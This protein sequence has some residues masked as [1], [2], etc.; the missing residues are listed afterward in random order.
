MKKNVFIPV[1]ITGL[2]IA[3]SCGIVY[4][5]AKETQALTDTI[6][7]NL[8]QEGFEFII[9]FEKGEKHNHP[10]FVFW[11]EDMNENLLQTLFVTKSFATGI[12]GHAPVNDTL[13]GT[14][15]GQ[16]KRPAALPYWWHKCN[17]EAVEVAVPSPENPYVDAYTGETPE[18]SFALNIKTDKIPGEKFRVL[19]EINQTWDW[20][21]FWTNNKFPED[22]DYKSS[23]QPSL[24]Y[25]VTIDPGSNIKEY[26]L[27][28]IG[29]GHYS[30]KD[31]VLYTD[32][33]TITTAKYIINKVMVKMY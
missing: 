29:H 26:Y 31:G 9:Y 7:V 4:N 8:S 30:G 24:I 25:S 23:S 14:G 28:P 15:P 3:S 20:N 10:T 5:P 32:L 19:M 33:S 2:F 21:N 11:T 27:N 17:R 16:A 18:S 13:W 22:N 6:T 1:M 12:F